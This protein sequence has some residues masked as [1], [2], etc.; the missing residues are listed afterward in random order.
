MPELRA[1]CRVPALPALTAAVLVMCRT[2]AVGAAADAGSRRG[3]QGRT[4]AEI[5]PSSVEVQHAGP[6]SHHKADVATRRLIRSATAG[7]RVE[8]DEAHQPETAFHI[9][10]ARPAASLLQGP[11]TLPVASDLSAYFGESKSAMEKL[12]AKLDFDCSMSYGKRMV[13]RMMEDSH[14]QHVCTG[15]PSN[16]VCHQRTPFDTP[17]FMCSLMNVSVS[18]MGTSVV[19]CVKNSYDSFVSQEGE[20]EKTLF[21]S[22]SGFGSLQ[23]MNRTV[24]CVQRVQKKAMVQVI[25]GENNFYEWLGD[26]VTL[27]ESL[28]AMKWDPKD[29]ELYLVGQLVGNGR[30]LQWPFD[31]GWMKAFPNGAVHVGDMKSLFGAGTCFDHLVTVPHGSVSTVTFRGG[32]GGNVAC[33]SPTVMASAMWLQALFAQHSGANATS[34]PANTTNTSLRR[35][36]LIERS[37]ASRRWTS[38]LMAEEAVKKVLPAGWELTVFRPE[39]TTTLAEQLQIAAHTQVLVGTHGA[40]LT[41]ALFLPPKARLVEVFC[42]DHHREGHHHF[43]NLEIMGEPTMDGH[44]L[45]YYFE[46]SPGRCLV[47]ESVVEKAVKA[48]EEDPHRF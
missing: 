4:V 18:E 45:N 14:A 23:F 40:G 11:G 21:G 16:I 41:H 5:G 12:D 34:T 39:E 13:T 28:V 32:R 36:T 43:R 9:F 8:M 22:L 10:S 6:A 31:E 29:V 42:G 46:D 3:D 30:L 24:H 19:G 20:T 48:Y 15:S 26:W 38:N 37:D 44:M 47:R 1:Q 25:R 35:V 33:P 17:R 7:A 27:W 2:C